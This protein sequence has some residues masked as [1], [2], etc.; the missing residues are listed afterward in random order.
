MNKR[1]EK[2]ERKGRKRII[3]TSSPFLN[4]SHPSA[5]FLRLPP[6]PFS[7][8]SYLSSK[9]L[10]FPDSSSNSSSSSTTTVCHVLTTTFTRTVCSSKPPYLFKPTFLFIFPYTR[11]S[12]I[13]K[14]PPRKCFPFLSPKQFISL[15]FLLATC[16]N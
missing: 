11:M 2:A 1:R 6:A 12:S 7:F 9:S 4:A 5:V 13:A 8:F 14:Q 10:F 15:R 16:L 3:K